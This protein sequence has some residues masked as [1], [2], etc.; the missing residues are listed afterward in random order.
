MIS[1][2]CGKEWNLTSTKS[3]LVCHILQTYQ[4][5]HSQKGGPDNN[6]ERI[7]RGVET[8]CQVVKRVTNSKAYQ[9]KWHVY[10]KNFWPGFK[11]WLS[12]WYGSYQ[13]QSPPKKLLH[14]LHEKP[15]LE[16]EAAQQNQQNPLSQSPAFHTRNQFPQSKNLTMQGLS[17]PSL[18]ALW[19]QSYSK[20]K[21]KKIEHMKELLASA[22]EQRQGIDLRKRELTY[23]WVRGKT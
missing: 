7:S 2:I 17:N 5:L 4:Y 15:E 8:P 22:C 23:S 9:F 19:Y 3:D 16:M 21:P 6:M 14:W 12:R 18:Q 10:N 1:H 20:V 13:P 11:I